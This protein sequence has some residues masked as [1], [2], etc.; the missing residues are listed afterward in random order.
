MYKKSNSHERGV[1]EGSHLFIVPV[2]ARG[3][4]HNGLVTVSVSPHIV[5]VHHVQLPAVWIL[6]DGLGYKH[7][8][9]PEQGGGLEGEVFPF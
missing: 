9:S 1:M 3:V 7:R 4:D 8:P 2:T 5:P 6:Q